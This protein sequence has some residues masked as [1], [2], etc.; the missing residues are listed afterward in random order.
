MDDQFRQGDEHRRR[1]VQELAEQAVPLGAHGT[2]QHHRGSSNATS[3]RSRDAAY[4]CDRIARDRPD[5]L[6]AM[7]RGEY[8]SVRAAAIDAGVVK[9][10]SPLPRLQ[11][12]WRQASPAARRK[13][14][15]NMNNDQ[16][17]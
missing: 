14:T 17:H 1:R 3:S 16:N 9:P 2:N 6:A 13:F 7:Q 10:E 5:I 11:R 8:T 15:A 12:A 4:W